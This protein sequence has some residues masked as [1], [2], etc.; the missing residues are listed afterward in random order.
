MP[1][2]K[3]SN[4]FIAFLRGVNVGGRGM[5]AM[6]ELKTL[7]AKEGF[8]DVRTLLQS[9]NVVFKAADTPAEALEKKIAAAI[10]KRFGADIKVMV[11]T[12]AELKKTAARNPY[13]N[14]ARDDPGHLLIAF[15]AEKPAAPAAK[16]MMALA[17]KFPNEPFKLDGREFFVHYAR[18]IGNSKFTNVIIEKTLAVPATAR[19]WNTVT[20]LI[21][22][23][24]ETAAA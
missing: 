7:L 8:A 19:N 11:R 6:A 13:P 1:A 23:A 14:A 10:A 15:L 3:R 16:A 22:L 2:K 24:D 21:A 17:P 4:V 12:P 18:D 5:I 9:G 20:K